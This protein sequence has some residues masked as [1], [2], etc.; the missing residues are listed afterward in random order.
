MDSFFDSAHTPPMQ[1]DADYATL[2][3]YEPGF[4]HLQVATAEELHDLN[5]LA[6]NAATAKWVSTFFHEY[7][8]FLQDITSTHGLLNFLHAVQ[9]LKNANKQALENK[10]AAFKVPLEITNAFNFKTNTA[11]RSVYYG[12]SS[13]ASSVTYL[14]Y[15]TEYQNVTTNG[16][17]VLRVPKYRIRYYDNGA[18][19]KMVCHFGSLHIKEYMAHAIQNQF[20]PNTPHYD[21]PY[22]LVEL[23][24]K[25]EYPP[26]GADTSLILALCD[27]ALMHYH[28]AQLFFHALTKMRDA[29]WKPGAVDSVYAFVFDGLE[30]SWEKRSE[31]VDS[32]YKQTSG[33][34]ISEFCDCLRADIF[35]DNVKWFETLISEAMNLRAAHRGFFTKLVTSPGKFSPLFSEIIERLGIPF[36]TNAASNGY[37]LPPEK[38][39][40]LAIYPYFPRV[41]RAISMTYRGHKDCLLHAFCEKRT[42]K[43][44]TD[45]HCLNSPW[46]RV[47]QP[48]LCPYAQ[49]WKTWGLVGKKPSS[50]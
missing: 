47:N 28:P 31:T 7:I 23:I 35:R 15:V 11:L 33:A 12:T 45:A 22:V 2:G 38:L 49:M 39:K 40:H 50:S 5:K 32:L 37:F 19:T 34:A 20:A 18:Q 13:V 3:Y 6:A 21:I 1:Y 26:L 24:V 36:L 48:E 16:G 8:H 25:K 30:L 44:V 42:D 41:F 14:E 17:T 43:K 46:E 29:Q 27:A 10:Q 4:I 9:Y